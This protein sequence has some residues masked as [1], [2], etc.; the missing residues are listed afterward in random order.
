MQAAFKKMAVMWK[1]HVSEWLEYGRYF[2]VTDEFREKN[3]RVDAL[4]DM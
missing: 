4:L 3:V 1:E 2:D